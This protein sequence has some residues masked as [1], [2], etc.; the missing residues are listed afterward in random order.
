M[1]YSSWTWCQSFQKNNLHSRRKSGLVWAPRIRGND[2]LPEGHEQCH[3]NVVAF[4]W[5]LSLAHRQGETA[6]HA[7]HQS[8]KACNNAVQKSPSTSKIQVSHSSTNGVQWQG[9]RTGQTGARE[10]RLQG[11][12]GSWSG[13][14]PGRYGRWHHRESER[15]CACTG[16]GPWDAAACCPLAAGS[17]QT[18]G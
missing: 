6:E 8:F 14:C 10:A 1:R 16:C 15:L 17:P 4:V 9:K 3:Q 7:G 18:A 11:S 12:R 13:W 5:Q 2:K